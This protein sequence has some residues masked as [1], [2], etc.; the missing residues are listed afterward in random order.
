LQ[1]ERK[2]I[3]PVSTVGGVGWISSVAPLPVEGR[4]LA[5]GY[6]SRKADPDAPMRAE[7][8]T[9]IGMKPV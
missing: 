5:L 2:V 9:V 8:A 4:V 3:G 1:D 6:L 7:D